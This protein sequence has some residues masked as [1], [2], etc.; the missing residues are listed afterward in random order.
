MKFWRSQ[1]GDDWVPA[2]HGTQKGALQRRVAR[3]LTWT[4]IDSWGGQLLQFLIF[5]ILAHLLTKTDFGLVSLAI[6]FVNFALLFVDQGL[7]DA[8]IQRPKVT[9]SQ[10]NTA[11]WVAIVTGLLLMGMGLLV[12]GPLATALNE[13]GLAPIVMVL[14]LGFLITSL[15]SVQIALLRR[16]M[17]FR[18]LA[19]RRLMAVVAGGTA[20]VGFAFAG[21]GVWALVAQQLTFGVVSVIMLWGVSP[22]RPRL[23]ASMSDFREL[24]SFGINIVGTD[25]MLY[26]S[27]NADNLLVGAVLGPAAL[28]LY[29]IGYKILETSQTILVQAA[30]KLAFPVFSRLAHDPVRLR[31]VYGRVNRALSVVILP[32]YIGLA[33]VAQEAVP[34]IFGS[35]WTQSGP[36][37]S[38]L[39]L[40]GPVLTI[41][42][43]SGALINATGHPHITLRFRLAT[44]IVHVIGFGIAVTVFGSIVAVAAAFVIGSYMLLPA[45]L[46]ILQRY[47]GIPIWDMLRQLRGAALAT[48]LMAA[49]VLAVKFALMD[50]V[51]R[52]VLLVAEIAVGVVVFIAALVFLERKLLIE[53]VTIALQAVPGGERVGRR[54]HLPVKKRRGD[55][56]AAR[57]VAAALEVELAADDTQVMDI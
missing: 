47:G 3:G 29:A 10:L 18:G 6:V 1:A 13:P 55:G 34:L 41:Q 22:W 46:Y 7:G 28:G 20:G 45:N 51:G 33:L 27:R 36:V 42:V 38:T 30:R 35:E 53:V 44:M 15:S 14:S 52:L 37:A 19:L 25:V 49:A 24:F 5:A 39:F 17:D 23:E 26:V 31:R 50:S 9:R 2:E 32:G 43:A 56:R 12:A 48:L 16:E 8:L 11:F 54:L 40:I 21:F 57:A 4:L